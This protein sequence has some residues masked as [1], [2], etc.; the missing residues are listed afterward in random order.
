MAKKVLQLVASC[1][2]CPNK[3]YYSGGRSECTEV[4]TIL[5]HNEGHKIPEWCPLVDYPSDAMERQRETISE[6]RKQLEA[7]RSPQENASE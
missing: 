5:P 6:L 4:Q 7:Q 2:D 1:D 3:S